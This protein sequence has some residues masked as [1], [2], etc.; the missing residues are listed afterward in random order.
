MY[1]HSY[2]I[3]KLVFVR[4]RSSVVV[5]NVVDGVLDGSRSVLDVSRDASLAA[6][7]T[8][9]SQRISDGL[10]NTLRFVGLKV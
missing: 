4:S 10:C 7:L 2:I 6:T 3:S 1:T 9:R 8:F 5:H